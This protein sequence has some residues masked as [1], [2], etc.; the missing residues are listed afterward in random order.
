MNFAAIEQSPLF[1]R[2]KDPV[3][4]VESLIL[5]RRVAPIQQTFYFTHSGFSDD[6]RYL[7]FYVAFPPS[8]DAYSGRQ[9]GVADF[10]EQTLRYYPETLF[11]D[12]SPYVD[13]KTAEVYWVAGLDVWKRGPRPEDR[14]VL[15]NSFPAELARNRRPVRIATHL[16]PSADG[17]SFAIDA[18]IGND[19]FVG[20]LPRD[21]TAFRLW[22]RVDRCYNHAQFSPTDPDLMLLAQ[23]G[24]FNA[25]TGEPGVLEDRLW[26]IRRGEGLRQIYPNSPSVLRGHE[27]W[28]PD[29][30]HVWY[31]DYRK[32]TE[33]V[34]IRTGERF[35]VWPAGHTHSH[36]DR[37]GR[38]IVG[39]VNPQHIDFNL[40]WVAFFNAATGKEIKIVSELPPLPYPRSRYHV[41]PHPHFCL[42]DRWIAYTTN[43]LGTVDVAL[44][45]VEQ[46]IERTSG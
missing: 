13:P 22:Q 46:L 28:D 29:G 25:A 31:I 20:D 41:H 6:G 37:T 2:W 19:C 11:S 10:E 38:L 26:L 16:S 9:L 3:C 35:N 5:S 33:K 21:G 27:W 36:A 34:N 44:V 45:C 4:G 43:V 18:L 12:A 40:W 39:D 32:G 8:G 15:I 23:D 24:W 42:N 17:K 14:P 30:V 7:W 1:V